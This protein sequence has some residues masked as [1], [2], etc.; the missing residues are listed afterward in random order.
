MVF[1]QSLQ[2]ILQLYVVH[3]CTPDAAGVASVIA[4]LDRIHSICF[5]SQ[6]LKVSREL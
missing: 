2:D 3:A 4:E 5:Q 6:Q 1:R